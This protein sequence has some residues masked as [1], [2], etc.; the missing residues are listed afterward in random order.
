MEA[1]APSLAYGQTAGPGTQAHA[2]YEEKQSMN[3]L[4]AS[5]CPYCKSAK[6]RSG[7]PDKMCKS[8]ALKSHLN[9][10]CSPVSETYWA[11]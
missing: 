7:Q 8:H 2:D 6:T 11:S 5:K 1:F 9:F 4:A 10:A 3:R